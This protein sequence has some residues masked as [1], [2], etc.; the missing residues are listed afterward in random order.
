MDGY[1]EVDIY[2]S[3]IIWNGGDLVWEGE[4]FDKDETKIASRL[5]VVYCGVMY[6]SKSNQQEFSLGE[7]HS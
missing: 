6:F 1:I 4:M 5:G 3:D 2:D 7:V